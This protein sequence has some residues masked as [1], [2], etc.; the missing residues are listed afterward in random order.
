MI[1]DYPSGD[2]QAGLIMVV[3]DIEANR[4]L[5]R[6]LLELRGHEVL[7]A[8]DGVTAL[9]LVAEHAP[10]VV[11]LDVQMPGI[12][13][14][15]VCRRLK[16]SPQTASIPVILVTA[17]S[18]REH[19]LSGIRSG[20]S[21]YITKPI[22]GTDL[23]LRVHNALTTRRLFT[24]IE[25]QYRTLEELE[26]LRDNLVHMIVHDLRSPLTAIYGSLQLLELDGP[27]LG[28]DIADTLENA[29]ASTQRIIGLVSDM[30]D[31]SRMEAGEMPLEIE[32]VN[33]DELVADAIGHVPQG[34]TLVHYEAPRDRITV[35]CDR[36]V[37]GRVISNLLDNAIKF[38]PLD[39][40]VQM[41]AEPSGAG[42]EIT[43]RDSGSGIPPDSRDLIFEKFGQVRGVRREGRSSG[44]GLAFCK[45]A[46]EAHG[47]RIGC[48]SV[49]GEGSKFWIWLAADAPE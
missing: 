43:I 42:V 13:G 21:D 14:L 27:Q 9:E 2:G 31:V 45:L 7:E 8:P 38:S 26:T 30:L 15:E 19:R 1:E 34:P 29:L 39:A 32:E 37:I 6:D 49:A 41:R 35:P 36:K 47:G 5:I 11:L 17:L 40:T 24:Q 18:D 25:A 46:V 12:D 10:E 48:E 20:A 33:V 3:D 16:A 44:L 23:V 28:P 4:L 22:D